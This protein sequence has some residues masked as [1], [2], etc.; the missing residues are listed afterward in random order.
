MKTTLKNEAD[1]DEEAFPKLMVWTH[2]PEFVVLF[3]KPGV[4]VVVSGSDGVHDVGSYSDDWATGGFKMFRGS[5]TL[6]N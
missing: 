5:I 1:F 6:E 4:G 2:D 3:S